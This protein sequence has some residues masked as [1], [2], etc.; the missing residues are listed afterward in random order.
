MIA[1][2]RVAALDALCANR[3]ALRTDIADRVWQNIS[4]GLEDAGEIGAT[5][6]CLER[7]GSIPLEKIRDNLPTFGIFQSH[8]AARCLITAGEADGIG[9]LIGVLDHDPRNY[10]DGDVLRELLFATRTL[11]A[12][13]SG[14]SIRTELDGWMAHFKAHPLKGMRTLPPS[15]MTLR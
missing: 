9:V 15:A 10:D 11:L 13:L 4:H 12:Q 8:F 1:E 14:K 2:V 3:C 5:F 7:S 6:L